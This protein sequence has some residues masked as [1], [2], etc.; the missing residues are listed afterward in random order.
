M[1]KSFYYLRYPAGILIF[2]IGVLFSAYGLRTASCLAFLLLS[3]EECV[4]V[5]LEQGSIIDLRIFFSLSWLTGIALSTLKLSKLQSP[6]GPIMWAVAGGMYFFLLLGYDVADSLIRKKRK[7]EKAA[8]DAEDDLFS[9]DENGEFRELRLEKGDFFARNGSALIV[10]RVLQAIAIILVLGLGCFAVECVRFRFELPILSDKPH[11]YSEF[12]ITGLHY[13]VVSL[14]FIP[15]LSVIALKGRKMRPAEM[16]GLF[17]ANAASF[18]VPVLILSKFQ[19]L[20]TVVLPLLVWF[21]LRNS[22]I[23]KSVFFLFPIGA[24]VL[25]AVFFLLISRRSY[26]S[27]YLA[28]IFAFYDQRIPIGIQYP[29][30]Y[31]VNNFENLNLLVENL[32]NYSFGIRQLFPAFAL[33]GTKFIPAVQSMMAVERYLTSEELTTVTMAYDAFGDFGFTGVTVLGFLVGMAD[34]WITNLLYLKKRLFALLMYAQLAVY[35]MLSFFTTWFSNPTT[36]FWFA[37]SFFIALYATKPEKKF[38][39]SI[40]KVFGEKSDK[41]SGT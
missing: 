21:I 33:T 30:I 9:R 1:K 17:I 14:I 25:V 13:F 37:A 24:A 32:Q 36:W 2:L 6:W 3:I 29:Y 41:A 23:R 10:R 11:M 16:L 26:P 7:I 34:A 5:F 8:D 27:G 39:F 38:S 20:V 18:I 35:M 31:I 28:R 19:L 4:L 22:N 12:H 40:S 15:P